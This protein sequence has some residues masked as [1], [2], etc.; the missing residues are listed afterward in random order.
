MRGTLT[1]PWIDRDELRHWVRRTL[2]ALSQTGALPTLPPVGSAVLTLTRAPHVQTADVA[3]VIGTDVGLTTR[4]LRLASAGGETV[5]TLPAAI[6]AIGA[7][8]TCDFL[9]TSATRQLF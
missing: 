5:A 4:V 3:R 8:K 7:R 1:H 6:E 9:V 2:T